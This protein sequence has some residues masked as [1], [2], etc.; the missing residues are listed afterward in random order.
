[1][2]G[3]SKDDFKGRSDYVNDISKNFNICMH[4]A[5]DKKHTL[6]RDGNLLRK[7]SIILSL[8]LVSMPHSCP[9][10]SDHCDV[11]IPPNRVMS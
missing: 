9:R 1:M 6:Y 3:F 8:K 11:I 4:S 2:D 5:C 7:W 10:M